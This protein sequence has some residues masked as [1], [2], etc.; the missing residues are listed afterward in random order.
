MVLTVQRPVEIA[1]LQILDKV[2]TVQTVQK[3]VEVVEIPQLQF[4]DK[5]LTCPPFV[6]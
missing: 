6:Q 2:P 1:Q 3:T 5:L 4:L